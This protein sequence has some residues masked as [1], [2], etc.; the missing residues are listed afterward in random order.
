MEQ[1]IS[2]WADYNPT[3]LVPK[4]I[5]NRYDSG[6]DRFY[7]FML[8]GQRVSA[9]GITT[10]LNKIMPE[11]PFLTSWKLQYGKDWQTVLNLTADYG[12]MMHACIA[13][14]MINNTHPEEHLIEQAKSALRELR[15]FDRSISE[16]TIDKNIISFQKFRED[17]KLR[18]LLIEAKLACR[19]ITGDYYCLTQD[20]LAEAEVPVKTKIMV[21]D[22]EYVRGPK[23]G[24]PK[25]VEETKTDYVKQIIALDAKSNY[26]DSDKKSFFDAHKY[27]LVATKKAVQQNFGITVDRLFN[28]SPAGWRT[29][30]GAYTLHE[31][32]ITDEDMKT[33]E[34]YEQLASRLGHFRPKGDIEV[35]K[36][37]KEGVTSQQMY[38]KYAYLDYIEKMSNETDQTTLL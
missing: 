26:R 34:L 22:G 6:G 37:Y 29:D 38:E 25:M 1:S 15:K 12:T 27:Q 2:N 3:E 35:F 9:S 13:H 14:M 20:L 31:W 30:V 36:P 5:V 7:H 18:P 16:N 19:A 8:D 10:W 23:K 21:Q 28:W 11:S 4:H 24:Q 32:N 17:Y 33:F